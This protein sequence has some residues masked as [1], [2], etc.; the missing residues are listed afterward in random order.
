MYL[1]GLTGSIGSG[2]SSVAK[3][4]K[5]EGFKILDADEI[6][7]ELTSPK[8]P[9]IGE[10]VDAFGDSIIN[11]EGDL[12][13]RLLASI[14]FKTPEKKELLSEI[15]T[16][17]VKTIMEEEIS[18]SKESC[19]ILDVPLLFEYEMNSSL[20]EVWSVVADDD[21]RFQRAHKR[22][23]IT[24][25]DF[26]ARNGMQL[27]QMEKIL[28]SDVVIWNN[29]TREELREKVYSEIERVKQIIN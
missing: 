21:I 17:K 1:I 11:E 15:V 16:M 22:D 28:L 10:L 24:K 19:L 18:N 7:R 2:K 6:S 29:G 23:G 3:I 12:D 9:I 4:L 25:E 20:D 14:A 8:S 13:R 5:S 26:D 27:S